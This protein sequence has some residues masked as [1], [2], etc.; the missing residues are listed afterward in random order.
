MVDDLREEMRSAQPRRQVFIVD[1]SVDALVDSLS[2]AE[3]RAPHGA[4]GA[5][6]DAADA[7]AAGAT[8]SF[9]LTDESGQVVGS[10]EGD[11]ISAGG[12]SVEAPAVR[13]MLDRLFNAE[14]DRPEEGG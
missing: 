12:C 9:V 11:C 14:N 2:V 13:H 10:V 8:A 4:D 6:A 1:D 3:S 7:D 5:D